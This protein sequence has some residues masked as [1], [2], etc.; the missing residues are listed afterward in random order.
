MSAPKEH[1][2]N[3]LSIINHFSLLDRRQVGS[4]GSIPG[5]KNK[6]RPI[7]SKN[8]AMIVAQLISNGTSYRQK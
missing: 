7:Q 4:T 6:K 5:P 2:M 3:M 8:E 1:K